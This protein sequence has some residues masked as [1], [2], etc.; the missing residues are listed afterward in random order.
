MKRIIKILSFIFIAIIF[1]LL[2]SDRVQ[3]REILDYTCSFYQGAAIPCPYGSIDS[4]GYICTKD[5]NSPSSMNTC[6]RG[7]KAKACEDYDM[8]TGEKCPLSDDY[9]NS[10]SGSTGVCTTG[11][12]ARTCEQYTEDGLSCPAVDDYNEMK[13][14]ID[15]SNNCISVRVASRCGNTPYNRDHCDG[16]TD[17]YGNKCKLIAGACSIGEKPTGFVSA[18]ALVSCNDIFVGSCYGTIDSYGNICAPS[19]NNCEV[20]E[21][22]NLPTV[23]QKNF[24]CKDFDTYNGGIDCPVVDSYG[25]SCEMDETTNKCYHPDG[26]KVYNFT[27]EELYL[28]GKEKNYLLEAVDETFKCSDVIFLTGVY[29]L[30]RIVAPFLVILLGSLDFF[31]SMM[32]NDEKKMKESQGKFVKRIIAFVL[33]IVLPFVVQFVFEKIGTFGSDNMCLVKCVVSNN[34]TEKGCD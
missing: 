13:C 31:R 5:T 8:S 23:E 27:Y 12:K 30:I 19:F 28:S 25:N 26:G 15:S 4:E 6:V 29:M 20:E 7:E 22:T 33:L 17:D 10:C 1:S 14:A 16:Y 9:G 34:T 24:Y 3:A 11:E 2:L 32:Q 18:G 21:K